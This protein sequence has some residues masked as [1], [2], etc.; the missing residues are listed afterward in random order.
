M[1]PEVEVALRLQAIDI[2][3]SDLQKEIT[4]LPKHIAEIEKKLVGHER[5]LEADR[6]AL[7]ANQKERKSLEGEI[8]TTEGKISKLRGQMLE[9]KTNEQYRAFQNEIEFGEKEIRGREDKILELMGESEALEKNVKAAEASLK[10]QR[11]QV[12]SERADTERRTSAD[13]KM[14]EK[15]TNERKTEIGAIPSQLAG[16]YERIRKG[17][18]GIAVSEAL[19]GRCAQCHMALRPQFLQELKRSGKVM[20][21]ESCGRILYWNPP[22]SAED[23][24][25]INALGTP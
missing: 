19:D 7:A 20:F 1:L 2:Q 22:R 13:R 8:Q 6:A 3:I 23:L 9:A 14:V 21:C 24:A 10:E 17:R 18:G 16:D 5:R 15:L 11:K 25:G 12:E 4:S